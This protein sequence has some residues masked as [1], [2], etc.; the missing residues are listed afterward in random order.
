MHKKQSLLFRRAAIAIFGMSAG[1]SFFMIVTVLFFRLSSAMVAPKE[2]GLFA[3]VSLPYNVRF[4]WPFLI[5]HFRIPYF[6]ARLGQRRSWGVLAQ[7]A[8]CILV[9][10]LG[11][12]DP[13]ANLPRTFCLAT[14]LSFFSALHDIVSEIYRFHFAEKIS[15]DS[16]VPL[17]TVGF[18]CGQ[19]LAASLVPIISAFFGWLAG[20]MVVAI[21]KIAAAFFITKLEEPKEKAE[22]YRKKRGFF[23]EIKGKVLT[24]FAKTAQNPLLGVFLLSIILMRIIDTVPGPLQTIFIGKIGI[25]NFDFGLVKGGCGIIF[26]MLGIPTASYFV[27]K[28]GVLNAL[29]CGVLCQSFASMLSLLLLDLHDDSHVLLLMSLSTSFQ[30]FFQGFMNTSIIIYISSF[31]ETKLSIYYFTL[32]STISSMSRSIATYALSTISTT[33]GWDFVF[34]L[35]IMLCFPLAI[36]FAFLGRKN[37]LHNVFS[38]RS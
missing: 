31:C 23:Q 5:D 1:V 24:I 30:D 38:H 3:F 29:F 18:R 35:P 6:A 7:L 17:Q 27:K 14:L 37:C 2:I 9:I 21:V 10:L 28:T 22:R 19:F 12:T 16:S 36:V 33:V 20:H 8:S 25:S 34:C 32:F 13:A 4:L 26:V 11:S 15:H